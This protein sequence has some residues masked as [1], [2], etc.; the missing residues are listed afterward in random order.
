MAYPRNVLQAQSSVLFWCGILMFSAF[1]IFLCMMAF[2]CGTLF[3]VHLSTYGTLF[4]HAFDLCYFIGIMIVVWH[5]AK[6]RDLTTYAPNGTPM[7]MFALFTSLLCIVKFMYVL[8]VSWVDWAVC[9]SVA[10]CR[11][12][13][14]AFAASG[15]NSMVMIVIQLLAIIVMMKV[16]SIEMSLLSK[17]MPHSRHKHDQ[18]AN[19]TWIGSDVN[20][21]PRQSSQGKEATGVNNHRD[22]IQGKVSVILPN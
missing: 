13:V 14:S 8:R 22:Y 7:R 9:Q 15:V 12:D 5:S 21:A 19:R 18:G 20:N 11:D 16:S 4:Y 17:E 1:M 3:S 10:F 6:I 2:M